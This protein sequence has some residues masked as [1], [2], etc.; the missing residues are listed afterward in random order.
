MRCSMT[1][2]QARQLIHVLQQARRRP[3]MFFPYNKS[4]ISGFL[5]GIYTVKLAFF[6]P[7]PPSTVTEDIL[8]ERGWHVPNSMG[9]WPEMEER[10]YTIEAMI[11]E[12]LIVEIETLRRISTIDTDG[13]AA[14][15]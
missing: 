3:G 7:P 13:E 9:C 5:A 6:G 4:G 15:A 11:E 2:E 8:R 12:V 14:K 10:H 1:E